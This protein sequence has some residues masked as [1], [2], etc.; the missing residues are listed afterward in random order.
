MKLA[1]AAKTGDYT[2]TMED[3][4]IGCDTSSSAITITL[5]ASAGDLAG[6]MLV[7]K[8]VGGN[9]ASL[10]ITVDGNSSETIDASATITINIAYG[11]V[12]LMNNGANWFIW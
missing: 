6:M 9:A 1:Y 5:P 12:N 4:F 11:S 10:A 2:A 7:I 8:D 3:T